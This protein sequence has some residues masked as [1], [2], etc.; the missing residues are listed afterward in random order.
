MPSVQSNTLPT[1]KS[2]TNFPAL[3]APYVSSPTPPR[4][5]CESCLDQVWNGA[6]RSV[7]SSAAFHGTVLIRI[8]GV[9]F[10]LADILDLRHIVAVSVA[11]APSFKNQIYHFHSG[12]VSGFGKKSQLDFLYL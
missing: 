12:E 1:H 8:G 3:S 7:V 6:G 9:E 10:A 5:V 2:T 11:P 4:T